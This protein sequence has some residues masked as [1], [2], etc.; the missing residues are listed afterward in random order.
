[1]AGKRLNI[2]MMRANRRPG[3][4]AIAHANAAHMFGAD[5][6]FFNPTGVDLDKS[7]IT[8]WR[9]DAS[10]WR[11]SEV[12]LPDVIIN[13]QSS[14]KYRK[15]WNTLARRVPFTAPPIGDKAEVFERM[16]N[17]GFYPDLQIPTVR[18]SSFT[19]VEDFLNLHQKIVVKPQN[20]S[21]G[22]KVF[23]VGVERKGFR[24]NTGASWEIFDADQL[25]SFYRDNFG[26]E[27][28]IAQKFIDS[29]DKN[30]TPFDIRLHVRRNR[31]GEWSV[32]RVLPRI[33]AGRSITSN[34]ADGGRVA[35]LEAFLE[36]QFGEVKGK[37]VEE[38]LRDL[39]NGMPERFQ[40]LYRDRR[41]DA[42]GIDI[43]LDSGAK[44]WL[45]EVNDF[46]GITISAVDAAIARVGYALYVVEHPS[47]TKTSQAVW[48]GMALRGQ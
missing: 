14:A 19:D 28:S 10:R 39:A 44:P 40:A 36:S 18:L 42:L 20:G 30:G 25:R 47:E 1:M 26:T 43:G 15:V 33:G 24:V 37:E 3:A 2:G 11:R 6:I 13:D 31:A 4:N 21:Q 5:F 41:L 46:P 23:F 12:S 17:G 32:I 34:V 16:R 35:P 45:F 22:R 8:G 27:K 38:G 29:T 7:T 9:Y 48:Q